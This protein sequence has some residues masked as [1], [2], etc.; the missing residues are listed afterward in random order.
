MK[1]DWTGYDGY[2]AG[3]DWKQKPM[4]PDERARIEAWARKVLGTEPRTRENLRGYCSPPGVFSYTVIRVPDAAAHRYSTIAG[5][6]DIGLKIIKAGP[7]P[8]PASIVKFQK[9]LRPRM[10]GLPH[11]LVQE[12]YDAGVVDG[13]HYVVQEW[14]HGETLDHHLDAGPPLA[15]GEARDFI[16]DYFVET[17]LLLWSVGCVFWD[18][19][20]ANLVITGRQGRRRVVMIDTDTLAAC[21]QEIVETPH[22]FEHRDRIKVSRGLARIKTMIQKIHASVLAGQ[23]LSRN[24]KSA[25]KAAMADAIEGGLNVLK[26]PG[27]PAN[28]PSLFNRIL[29][30]L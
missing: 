24:G 10:P 9:E 25:R 6:R 3:R 23:D 11:P 30:C 8:S 28:N 14:I 19:R 1:L 21:A 13:F 4:G 22:I 16:T 7:G 15:A 29:D 12:V 5:D 2:F 17:M 26:Q 18:H 20:P 27:L